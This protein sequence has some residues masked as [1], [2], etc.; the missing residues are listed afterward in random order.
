MVAAYGAS[1]SLSP[2]AFLGGSGDR[3]SMSLYFRTV[4]SETPALRAT[5]A[6]GSPLLHIV[7]IS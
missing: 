2:P 5:S 7:R 3:S 6:T 4:G 1:S